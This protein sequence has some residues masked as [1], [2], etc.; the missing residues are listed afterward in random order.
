MHMHAYACAHAG[1]IAEAAH[2]FGV[3]GLPYGI[4][5]GGVL[6]GVCICMW[7]WMCMWSWAHRQVQSP[8]PRPKPPTLAPTPTQ[9]PTQ[10]P[11]L[12]SQAP[13]FKVQGAKKAGRLP[14]GLE[15]DIAPCA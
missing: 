14:K 4:L 13:R 12:K 15:F 9:A 8:N 11:N 3:V 2:Q 10:A 1:D 6:T 5:S 7:M